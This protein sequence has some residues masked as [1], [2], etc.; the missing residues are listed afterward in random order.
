ME[1][2]PVM[3]EGI[4]PLHVTRW[5]CKKHGVKGLIKED[6]ELGTFS[7]ELSHPTF[8]EKKEG[9]LCVEDAK[10]AMER[11]IDLWYEVQGRLLALK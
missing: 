6:T 9:F 5:R 1:L 10:W 7:Y 4:S 8:T 2:I 11:K 3:I